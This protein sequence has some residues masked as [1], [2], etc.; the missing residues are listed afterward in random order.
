MVVVT[1]SLSLPLL[2]PLKV[3]VLALRVVAPKTKLSLV[4][5][6]V[7]VA[8]NVDVPPVNAMLRSRVIAP[9]PARVTLPVPETPPAATVLKL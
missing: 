3:K 6:A 1:E 4:A 8:V 5:A 7:D 9:V 2:V